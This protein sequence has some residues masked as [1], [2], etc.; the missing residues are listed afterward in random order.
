MDVAKTTFS[1]SVGG[2]GW[3][4]IADGATYSSVGVFNRDEE[5]IAIAIAATKPADNS[6]DYFKLP[7]EGFNIDLG[8][9]DKLYAKAMNGTVLVRGFRVSIA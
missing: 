2:S 3:Q 5:Q 9:G 7:N 8:T 4:L 1:Q 6:D